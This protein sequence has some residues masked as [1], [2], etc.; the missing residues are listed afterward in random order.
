MVWYVVGILGILLVG[1]LIYDLVTNVG[2]VPADRLFCG[3]CRSERKARRAREFW[4]VVLAFG[5]AVT[6]FWGIAR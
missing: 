4:I 5:W 3:N 6:F 1:W 2:P